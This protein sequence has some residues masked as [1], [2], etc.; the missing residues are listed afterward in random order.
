[1]ERPLT[2]EG[3]RFRQKL[4]SII[5]L[6]HDWLCIVSFPSSILRTFTRSSKLN[7]AWNHAKGRKHSTMGDTYTST[8]GGG[9]HN[10]LRVRVCAAHMGGFLGPKFSKQGSLFRQIFLKQGWLIQKLAKNSKNWV[11][12]RQNSS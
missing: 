4:A 5:K 9:V 12:F 7:D 2:S 11:V 8:R 1:M 10:M 6:S 3:H